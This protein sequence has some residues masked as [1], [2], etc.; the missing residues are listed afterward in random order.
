[1]KTLILYATK[2]GGTHEAAKGVAKRILGAV[3]HDLKQA[4]IPPIADFDCV[5]TEEV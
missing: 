2:H 3:L 5:M 4:D 1:M